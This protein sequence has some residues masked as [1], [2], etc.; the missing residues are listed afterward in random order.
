MVTANVKL[1]SCLIRIYRTL[2]A[3]SKLIITIC[4]KMLIAMKNY[5]SLHLP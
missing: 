3:F 5:V 4:I 2:L 1:L